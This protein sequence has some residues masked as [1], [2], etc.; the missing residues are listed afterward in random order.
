M[1]DASALQVLNLKENKLYGKLPHNINE[2]CMIEALDFSS[3][4]IGGQL[5]RSLASCKYLEVLDIGNNQISDSF[6]CW[7]TALPRLQILVLADIK[8]VPASIDYEKTTY[9]FSN[10]RILALASINFSGILTEE[11][12]IR[13]KSMIIEADNQ[14]LVME[15]N[16]D[17]SKVYEVN[18]MLTYK[19]SDITFSKILKIIVYI[20][21]SN[22]AIHGSIPRAIGELALLQTLNMSHNSFT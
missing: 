10:L 5:P 4:K 14:T 18:T 6:P 16:G 7:M 15:Y 1:E 9:D 19:G 13:L 8:Q 2:S 21:V 17:Q 11:W 20:E 22:N 3:N 12:F